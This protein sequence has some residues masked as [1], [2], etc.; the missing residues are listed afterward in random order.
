MW[1]TKKE[2]NRRIEMALAEQDRER[3]RNE[4][5]CELERRIER[6]DEEIWKRLCELEQRIGKTGSTHGDEEKCVCTRVNT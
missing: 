1:I 4:R 6:R 5:I 3:Y 2:L